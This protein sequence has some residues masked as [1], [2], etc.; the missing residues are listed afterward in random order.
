MGYLNIYKTKQLTLSLEKLGKIKPSR[1]HLDCE[2]TV[3]D[4]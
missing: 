3:K 4:I 1:A 2:Q